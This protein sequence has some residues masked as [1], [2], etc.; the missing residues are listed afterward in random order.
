MEQRL[1]WHPPL[2]VHCLLLQQLGAPLALLACW[3][4]HRRA[5]N[6]AACNVGAC[7]QRALCRR[8]I[9]RQCH[10][11][12]VQFRLWKNG[13]RREQLQQL[14]LPTP[15]HVGGLVFLP[16]AQQHPG[17]EDAPNIGLWVIAPLADHIERHLA[18]ALLVHGVRADHLEPR[19]YAGRICAT[20]QP[21]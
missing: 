7:N 4:L 13:A 19:H 11:T 16:S 9:R 20:C 15:V 3:R 1:L 8:P 5:C 12:P 21:R 14:G 10:C 2:E 6:V 17:F 18:T